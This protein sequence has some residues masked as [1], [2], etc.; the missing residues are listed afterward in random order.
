[1][2]DQRIILANGSRLI[3][4]MLKR[5]IAKNDH[6]KV[7]KEI[8]AQSDLPSAIERCAAEW[9]IMPLS[10]EDILPGW[11]D[12][13][14]VTHPNVRILTVA[15]DGSKVK[16]KW[17]ESHEEDL[18]NLSLNDLIRLLENSPNIA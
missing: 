13:Y 8:S 3:R 14:M 10:M 4:E 12:P 7:V 17:L 11:V 16:M 18:V 1:M 9:V 2:S 15:L 5:I 6:L